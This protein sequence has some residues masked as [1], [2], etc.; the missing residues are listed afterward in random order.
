MAANI[1]TR[2][3]ARIAYSLHH[4]GKTNDEF[5]RIGSGAFRIAFLHKPTG[6]VYKVNW[7]H[8][9]IQDYTNAGERKVARIL[10]RIEWDMVRIP[11][12]SLFT[13]KCEDGTKFYVSACEYIE[14]SLGMD[15]PNAYGSKGWLEFSRKV[16]MGDMHGGN[17]LIDAEG[18]FCPVDLGS[19]VEVRV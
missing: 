1:G 13:F 6:V 2:S 3:L 16:R 15:T 19:R 4:E 7:G 11:K 10:S 17:F 14:G 5:E 18:K 8:N 12:F 9:P